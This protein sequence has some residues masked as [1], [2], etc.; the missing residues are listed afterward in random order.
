[1]CISELGTI[2]TKLVEA[3]KEGLKIDELFD[4]VDRVT[5]DP[6]FKEELLRNPKEAAKKIK[7][8]R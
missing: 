6:R 7:S 3:C 2:I 1:M 4:G 8:K 5:K